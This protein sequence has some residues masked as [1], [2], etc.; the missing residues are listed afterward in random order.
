MRI[1]VLSDSHGS[2]FNTRLALEQQPEAKYVFH[3]GDG[4]RDLARVKDSY[5][6]KIFVQV[7]GNCDFYS[8]LPENEILTVENKKIFLTHG[9]LEQVKFTY[10]TLYYKAKELPA[11]IALFGHTHVPFLDYDDGMYI[12]NPGSLRDGLYGIIDI[13][14]AGIVCIHNK[15]RYE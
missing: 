10:T 2:E 5:P 11:D 4:E 1:L 14:D 13:T 15:V 9:Y 6:N 3:L 7:K 12:F 8:R